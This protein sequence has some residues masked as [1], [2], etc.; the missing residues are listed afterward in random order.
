MRFE[1]KLA[2]HCY[3]EFRLGNT[4][5]I[6]SRINEGKLSQKLWEMHGV[7]N[8]M[9][10]YIRAVRNFIDKNVPD[11]TKDTYTLSMTR[12]DFPFET[13]FDIADIT[14]NIDTTKNEP[15]CSGFYQSLR[16]GW[17]NL[18]EYSIRMGMEF[19]GSK[20]DILNICAKT[21]A[22]EITHAY[23]D[24]SRR[25][26][27]TKTK[28]VDDLYRA[29]TKEND[30][31]F[32]TKLNKADVYENTIS[33]LLYYLQKW[34]V[35][36]YI[37]QA[38]FELMQHMLGASSSEEAYEA[39]KKTRIYKQVMDMK[40]TYKLMKSLI[41]YPDMCESLLNAFN[42]SRTRNPF[43]NLAFSL[44]DTPIKTYAQLLTIFGKKI[45]RAEKQVM[46]VLPKMAYD[47]YCEIGDRGAYN[48]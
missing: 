2:K 1:D 6:D 48:R 19:S 25:R 7:M 39:I 5:S 15:D 17:K 4:K 18:N 36:A 3:I 9:D 12:E 16:S 37:A 30:Y 14:I 32:N 10:D 44:H 31:A 11:N 33:L 20:E 28:K 38:R 34:E 46:R 29:T 24:F 42:K 22:H 23:D 27:N 35:N 43:T 40:D 13:F 47:I 8:N 45:K 41:P 21:A 26:I